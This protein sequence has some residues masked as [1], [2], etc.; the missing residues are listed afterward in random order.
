MVSVAGAE[1][2]QLSLSLED[3]WVHHVQPAAVPNVEQRRLAGT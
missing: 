1:R 3:F 2:F